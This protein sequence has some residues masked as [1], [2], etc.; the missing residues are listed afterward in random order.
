MPELLIGPLVRHVGASD[1]T[2]W[3]ETDGPCEVQ[4]LGHSATTFQVAGH[5]YGLVCVEGLEPAGHYPYDVAL[6]GR[7]V[8]PEP[9]SDFPPSSIRTDR[10]RPRS[11]DPLRLLPRLGTARAPL[12]ALL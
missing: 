4:V 2:V 10:L 5:H 9:G 11:P 7:T 6:D 12:H 1:A 8:W 3:V